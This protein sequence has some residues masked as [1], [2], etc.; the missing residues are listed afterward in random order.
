M[1]DSKLLLKKNIIW[2]FIF[3]MVS[4]AQT[5][6]L[7]LFVNRILNEDSAGIFGFAFSVAVLLMYIGNFGIRNFQVSDSNE[8]YTAYEYYGFRLITVFLMLISILIIFVFYGASYEKAYAILFLG[9]ERVA[10]C[11]EDVFHGRYQ[12]KEKLYLAGMQG[13]IRFII[14]DFAFLAMLY[15]SKNLIYSCFLYFIVNLIF[16]IIFAIITLPSF[17]GFKISLKAGSMLS[18]ASSS[19]AL[20]CGY[21]LSTYLTNVP[22]YT[23]EKFVLEYPDIYSDRIQGYFNMLFM[24]V[25]MINLLSTVIFRP[26]IVKMAEFHLAGQKKEYNMLVY[27][28]ILYIA[29]IG[30]VILPICYF[31]GIPF[32]TFFYNSDLSSYKLEF[33]ILML[34]GL[35]SALSSFLNVCIITIRKQNILLI[36][37]VILSLCVFASNLIIPFNYG[38]M[39]ISVFYLI[40][41]LIQALLYFIIHEFSK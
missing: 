24:P 19:F 5:V 9:L 29:I 35:F 14:S 37:T 32:L 39:A 38:L 8:K 12:Q 10:E 21:F 4:A 33:M 31:I 41:M 18:I 30:I 23:I 28:Q 1:N 40:I 6:I 20:F 11:I 34:G 25:L 16:V 26:F 17:G 13:T 27:K 3:S 22:K 36:A 15:L 2:N 7:L